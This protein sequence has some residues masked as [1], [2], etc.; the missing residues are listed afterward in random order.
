MNRSPR[1]SAK[2]MAEPAEARDLDLVR[3]LGVLW[4]GKW[5]IALWIFLFAVLS[6]L[7]SFRV[8]TPLY[9]ATSVLALD[10]Q[11]ETIVDFESVVSGIG[12]DYY[13]IQTE[14]ETLRS[15]NLMRRLVETLALDQDPEFNTWLARNDP[16]LVRDAIRGVRGAVESV[17]TLLGAEP[18]AP[19]VPPTERELRDATIDELLDKLS[20]ASVRDSRV[21]RVS[22]QT[23]DPEKSALIADT[24]SELYILNQLEVKFDATEQ[25]T[26]W[27]TDRVAD[28]RVSLETAQ[29]AVKSFTTEMDL[30]SIESLDALN[31]QLKEFRDR[32]RDLEGRQGGYDATVTTLEAAAESSDPATMAAAAGDPSLNQILGRLAGGGESL[33]AS[34]DLRFEQVLQRAQLEQARNAQQINALST[35]VVQIE[36]QIEKQSADLVRLEEL[37]READASRQIYEYFLSRLK[38]TSVQGGI[39]QADSHVLSPAVVPQ[40]PSSPRKLIL[41]ITAVI[42]GAVTGI[43][44]TLLRELK[45]SNFRQPE[46]LAQLTGIGVLG[47]V[48]AAPSSSR[49]RVL[50]FIADKPHSA[51]AESVRNL[52][53]SILM[54]DVANPPKVV[55]LASSV[56]G[57]GKTTLTLSLANSFAGTGKRV[58]VIDGDI[59]RRTLNSYYPSD[60]REALMELVRGETTL[61]NAVMRDETLGIDLLLSEKTKTNAGDFFASDG[62]A[63]ILT[64]ARQIYDVVLVDTPP[65]LIVPDARMIGPLADSVLYVVRWEETARQMVLQGLEAFESVGVGISG[66][67]LNQVDTRRSAYYGGSYQKYG[68]KYYAQ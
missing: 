25:A 37:Q 29:N 32:I 60:R 3:L 14:L 59:R 62:F 44:L 56:P 16:N 49:A 43:L 7:Y 13:T 45:R 55:M 31:R 20:V 51:M 64:D 50:R 2:A 12:S 27:L 53:T 8:A 11:D 48:P 67:V 57:E 19:A 34:F 9:T 52:R 41:L 26:T 5:G 58:L 4:R 10:T 40:D 46:E 23:T 47:S 30:V 33:R 38:E 61:A 36:S 66:M 68:R 1:I 21:F 54:S 39:Q 42:L 18:A 28:L 15:R 63:R 35:S 65:V 6:I 24:L 22:V 17:S